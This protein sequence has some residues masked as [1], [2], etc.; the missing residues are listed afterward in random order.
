MAIGKRYGLLGWGRIR[1]FCL[2]WKSLG[3]LNYFGM[4]SERD[5]ELLRKLRESKD[6]NR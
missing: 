6:G 5:I 3:L 2:F 4:A 1:F